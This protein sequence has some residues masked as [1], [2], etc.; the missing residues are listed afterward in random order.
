MSRRALLL[1]ALLFLTDAARSGE[2]ALK[3]E[4]RGEQF[5]GTPLSWSP[6]HVFLLNRDGRVLEFHPDEA[7]NAKAA[8]EAFLPISASELRGAL[9]REFG[10]G[11]EVSGT[12][13]YLV[14]HPAGERNLWAERFEELYRSFVHY[15][16]ARGWRPGEPRFPLVAV[17]YPNR[18]AFAKAAFADGI[19]NP[20][21]VLGYYS[22]QSNRILMYDTATHPGGD[23]R[24][25]AETVIHEA[26]H[27]AAFNCGVHTRYADTPRWA[28]EGLGCLFEA[29]GVH[30]SSQYPHRTDRLNAY[31]LVTFRAR[32]KSR[33]PDTLARLISDDRLFQSNPDAAYSEAWMLSFFLS[34]TEPRKYLSYLQKTA[35]L[36]PLVEYPSPQRL[37]D[38]TDIF[39]QNFTMLDAR[40]QRFAAEL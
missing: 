3:F 22:I 36:K 19:S 31:R 14:V 13:H 27:Q 15:F 1:F 28:L 18:A 37:K 21:E 10:K 29:R 39:G 38:F 26:A 5:F 24:L 2:P 4:L 16:S 32:L 6:E 9:S 17:V 12:G 30:R 23:W 35:G 34:E 11:F 25:N 8:S 40:M 20:S 33:P 7:K